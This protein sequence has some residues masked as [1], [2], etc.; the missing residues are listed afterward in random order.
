MKCIKDCPPEKT[1]KTKDIQFNCIQNNKRCQLKC[2][3]NTNFNRNINGECVSKEICGK[4]LKK[5][6]CINN[7]IFQNFL[8]ILKGIQ[9]LNF[10]VNKIFKCN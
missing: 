7:E 8:L 1:C 10:A 3:C 9:Y 5:K 4:R 2:V 6:P